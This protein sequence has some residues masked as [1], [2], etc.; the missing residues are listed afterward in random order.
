M[1]R[2]VTTFL[3]LGVIQLCYSQNADVFGDNFA[4]SFTDQE[5]MVMY[6]DSANKYLYQNID[7]TEYALSQCR[8]IIEKGV[9][10]PDSISFRLEIESIYYEHSMNRPLAAYEIIV[11]HQNNLDSLQINE[12]NKSTF[13]Y[14]KG[15]THFILGDFE[16]AQ[17][18][19]YEILEESRASKD[20]AT[21][22]YSMYSLGQL[23][24]DEDDPEIS[25][26]IFEDLLKFEEQGK[27]RTS[28]QV[29]INIELGD[30]YVKLKQY[31]KALEILWRAHEIAIKNNLQVLQGEALVVIGGVYLKK[32]EIDAAK[33]VFTQLNEQANGAQDL[34][35]KKA[36]EQLLA[37]L[38]WAE[39]KYE[40]SLNSFEKIVSNMDTSNLDE[41]LP[42]YQNMHEIA[43]EMGDQ[44]AAYDYLLSFNKIKDSRDKDLKK[45]KTRYLQI[46]FNSEEKEKENAILSAKLLEDR[47]EKKILYYSITLAVLILMLVV[48][49]FYQKKM[50]SRNLEADVKKQ[51]I[52]LR[53]LNNKLTQ[54]NKELNEFN[55]ALSHDL[56]EPLRSIVGFSQLAFKELN[57][58]QKAK[59]YLEYVKAGG[60][61][62]SKLIESI[63]IYQNINDMESHIE[64]EE[65]S[66]DNLLKDISLELNNKYAEKTINIITEKDIELLG[67]KHVLKSVF[68]TLMDNAIK[69]NQNDEVN[70]EVKHKILNGQHNF[71]ITDNG[72]GIAPDYYKEIFDMFKRLQHRGFSA[73]PGL[74]L[75]IAQ[76]LIKKVGGNISVLN[77]KVGEGT[78][79][80]IVFPL[81]QK[82][83]EPALYI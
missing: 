54:S 82:S 26:D 14:L 27:L 56:K 74:G 21:I 45:Q 31:D 39:K 83:P 18:M 35:I 57:G 68:Q 66:I 43:S 24:S 44:K 5:K 50:Y 46:R 3:I 20:T 72:I 51:T 60:F 49:A 62:L 67:S 28:T 16:A 81:K 32:G 65:L 23:F 8:S 47:T 38:H 55:R 10:I 36:S 11:E 58:N 78:T 1:M 59:N 76:K 30:C 29:L 13:K 17:K 34:M 42:I 64:L 7:I 69:F 61:Q 22:I 15:F 53:L 80:S 25:I 41:L 37:N 63:N 33:S 77:S 79:F 40:T 73:G 12:A 2:L 9:T 75:S 52:D 19:Y 6:L 70:V 71:E 48:G 4:E